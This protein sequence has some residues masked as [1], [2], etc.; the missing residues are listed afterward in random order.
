MASK[1][2]WHSSPKVGCEQ[3]KTLSEQRKIVQSLIEIL[4]NEKSVLEQLEL[5]ENPEEAE[6]ADALVDELLCPI[7]YAFGVYYSL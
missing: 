1:C 2:Q 5:N 4:E 7:S 6:I 3:K